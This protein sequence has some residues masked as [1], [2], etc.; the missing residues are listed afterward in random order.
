MLF[1]SISTRGYQ[2]I[3]RLI[4]WNQYL[5]SYVYNFCR[6]NETTIFCDIGHVSLSWSD[7]F[8]PRSV[9]FGRFL[10]C[11]E[12]MLDFLRFLNHGLCCSTVWQCAHCA[13]CV[14][15]VQCV[16]HWNCSLICI[17]SWYTC[18]CTSKKGRHK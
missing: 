18:T 8:V 6:E 11:Q 2:K 15:L 7:A 16:Y 9:S 4:R 1:S 10:R 3:R 5:L 12:I 14:N 13:F 17:C